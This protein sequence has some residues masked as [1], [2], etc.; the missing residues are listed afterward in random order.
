MPIEERPWQIGLIVGPSG[1]GKTTIAREAFGEHIINGYEWDA[2]KAIVSQFPEDMSFRDIT[3]HLS[4]VGLSDIPAW[5][6]P[7]RAL[8]NGQQF[9]ATLARALAESPDL[10]VIDEFTS[11]VDRTVAK[12]S[13]CAVSKAI[14]R[15]AK[16][17]IALSCHYDIIE[18]LQPDWIYEPAGNLFQW[19][20]LRRRPAIDITIRRVDKA[21]WGIFKKHHYLSA[22]IHPGTQCFVAF[23]DGAPMA[24][25]GMLHFPHPQRSAWKGSRMVILPDYQGAGIGAA[26]FDWVASVFRA[27][28]KAVIGTASS[29]Q[30]IHQVATSPNWKI[31]RKPGLKQV[32]RGRGA[33]VGMFGS[34]NR[35]TCAFEYVGPKNFADAR[36]F[37]L[38]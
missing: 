11:V 9:R 20:L 30:M 22:D 10:F 35:R 18:W 13:S 38:V 25:L 34:D 27:T 32:N 23:C 19:R 1:C 2:D 21:A 14:R 8:S 28:G 26:L 17:M 3:S 36:G 5:K 15:G 37:G 4:S 16:R 29:P 33:G 12:I 7:F 6:R 24:F 31:T